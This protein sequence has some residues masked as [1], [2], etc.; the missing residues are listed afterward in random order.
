MIKIYKIVDNTNDDTYIG[1]T[2][3]TLKQR[4]V[5]HKDPRSKSVSKKIIENGDYR[6][7]LIEETD[8]VNRER[9]WILNT[10]CINQNI[11]GIVDPDKKEIYKIYKIVDN[12]NGNIYIGLTIQTLKE[13]LRGHVRHLD[14]VSRDIIKN[15]DY[16]IELIEETEDKSRERYWVINTECIN[17]SIPGRR[18]KEYREDNKEKLKQYLKDNKD[19]IKLQ[20]TGYYNRTK[21]ERIKKS[22]NYYNE[23]REEISNKNKEKYQENKSVM[24][25][26][27]RDNHTKNRE[28]NMTRMLLHYNYKKSWGGDKRSNNNLL[29][30][31]LN[32]FNPQSL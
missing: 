17:R 29:E 26:K 28:S 14:C 18:D 15:G 19:Y 16:K 21:E 30:I 13:R 12:T 3:Q 32:L 27:S 7:E 2:I 22:R 10:D 25:Q 4:L 5:G 6:M 20:R 9:Y 1:K 31:D 8:D 11:P 24:Q 23:N